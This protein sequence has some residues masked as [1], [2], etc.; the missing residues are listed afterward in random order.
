[1]GTDLPLETG[2]LDF[3][4]TI[5]FAGKTAAE[6]TPTRPLMATGDI[7]QENPFHIRPAHLVSWSRNKRTSKGRQPEAAG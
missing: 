3:K 4:A 7:I 1:M 2:L 6:V 5:T